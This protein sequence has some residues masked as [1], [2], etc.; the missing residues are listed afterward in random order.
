MNKV[1]TQILKFRKTN[2]N[3]LL[4]LNSKLCFQLERKLK[5]S[6][7]QENHFKNKI[8]VTLKKKIYLVKYESLIYS[9]RLSV[10]KIIIYEF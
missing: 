8:I 5:V 1:A 10:Y 4:N 3:F 2:V 9:F 7:S 6:K